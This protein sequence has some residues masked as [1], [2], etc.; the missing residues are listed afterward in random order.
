MVSCEM[1]M[2]R[3]EPGTQAIS[4]DPEQV[5]FLVLVLFLAFGLVLVFLYSPGCPGTQ[6]SP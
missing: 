2:V 4:P 3:I 5:I 6:K 1:C